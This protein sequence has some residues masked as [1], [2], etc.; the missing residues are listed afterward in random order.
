MTFSAKIAIFSI[1]GCANLKW[2]YAEGN[3]LS[4]LHCGIPSPSSLASISLR[5]NQLRYFPECLLSSA[6]SLGIIQLA[7]NSIR[8]LPDQGRL[9]L[10]QFPRL[11]VLDLAHNWLR[12]FEVPFRHV[13]EINVP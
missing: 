4:G 1:S 7:N 13:P 11:Q 8:H 3:A 12:H 6:G 5:S 2:L 10:Q 9:L